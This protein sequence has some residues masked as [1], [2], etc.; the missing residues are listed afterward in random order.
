LEDGELKFQAQL[1][2]A[3]D[4]EF[5]WIRWTQK[6]KGVGAA[7]SEVRQMLAMGEEHQATLGQQATK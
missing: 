6:Q 2:Q 7:I 3:Q 1:E 5:S 4:V